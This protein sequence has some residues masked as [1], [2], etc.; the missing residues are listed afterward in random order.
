MILKDFNLDN[1]LFETDK[2]Q[3]SLEER[4]QVQKQLQR[5]MA[6]IFYG[7]NYKLRR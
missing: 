7:R 6:E 5:E 2:D 3:L 1:Y 4:S